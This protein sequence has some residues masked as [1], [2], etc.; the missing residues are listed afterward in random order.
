MSYG[1]HFEVTGIQIRSDLLRTA[2]WPPPL[3]VIAIFC[4]EKKR[5]R[6]EN[7]HGI[8]V[9]LTILYMASE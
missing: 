9:Q 4:F 2:D 8:Y 1:T 3:L 7:M 5:H 6:R